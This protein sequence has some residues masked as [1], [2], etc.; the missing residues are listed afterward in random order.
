MFFYSKEENKEI[1]DYLISRNNNYDNSS[2]DDEFCENKKNTKKNE[3]LKNQIENKCLEKKKI[4]EKKIK[5]DSKKNKNEEFISEKKTIEDSKNEE[6][7]SEKKTIEDSKNESEKNESGEEEYIYNSEEN[8][9]EYESGEEEYISEENEKEYISEEN[10][11]EENEIK[12]NFLKNKLMEKNNL[13]E[14]FNLS[15][16]SKKFIN[17]KK[18]INSNSGIFKITNSQSDISSKKIFKNKEIE[19]QIFKQ[20]IEHLEKIKKL[21]I[22]QKEYFNKEEDNKIKNFISLKKSEEEINENLKNIL[23]FEDTEKNF[24]FSKNRDDNGK[25]MSLIFFTIENFRIEILNQINILGEKGTIGYYNEIKTHQEN[26]FKIKCSNT[27]LN[28][29]CRHCYLFK[30]EPTFYFIKNFK[31]YNFSIK[32]FKIHYDEKEKKFKFL[33][34]SL[35]YIKLIPISIKDNEN[36]N[37]IQIQLKN[38]YQENKIY[39]FYLEFISKNNNCKIYKFS[40]IFQIYE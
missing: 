7:I 16:D 15:Y 22:L 13:N 4:N 23:K 3:F 28:L 20:K 38:F 25:K 24:L 29:S 11:K 32:L 18:I 36:F 31:A 2:D 1:N 6:F 9:K 21:T 5:D 35:E 26:N 33:E 8:E 10:E 37:K 17:S 19:N 40:N 14:I 30:I 34:Q 39:F 12:E 27:C